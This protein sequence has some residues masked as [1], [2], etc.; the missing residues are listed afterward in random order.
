MWGYLHIC[1]RFLVLIQVSEVI[2][3]RYNENLLCFTTLLYIYIY[4][5]EEF[6]ESGGGDEHPVNIRVV[7][8]R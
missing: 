4:I 7:E 2:K 3:V 6:E 8:S 5:F 1:M